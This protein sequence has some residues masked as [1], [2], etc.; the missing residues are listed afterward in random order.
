MQADGTIPVEST[1]PEAYAVR[2]DAVILDPDVSWFEATKE[3]RVVIAG[4]NPD[5][6]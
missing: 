4:T 5:C 1:Q 6:P 3:R 2:S